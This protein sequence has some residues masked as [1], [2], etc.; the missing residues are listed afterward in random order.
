[1]NNLKAEYARWLAEEAL[2]FYEP[3]TSQ[4]DFHKSQAKIRGIFSGN[5]WGKTYAGCM[6]VAMT[7]DKVHPYRKNRVGAVTARDCCVSFNTIQAVLIPTYKRILPRSKAKLDGKTH[8]GAD[9]IWPG[10]RGGSWRTAWVADD[11]MLHLADGSFIEFKSYEQGREL[12]QGPPRHIIREDE[13]PKEMIHTENLARQFTTG[14]NLIMTMTPLKYSQWCF[15]QIYEASVTDPDIEVFGGSSRDNPYIDL[16]ALETLESM[17]TDEVEKAARLHGEFTFAKGR[18]WPEYGEHNRIPFQK[19]PDDW[20]KSIIIDPHP[21][22]PT[23]V[24][25]VAED[26]AGRLYCYREAN[27]GGTVE[28]I[29]NNIKVETNETISLMLIDPSSRQS[30]AI[31][32]QGSLV[33]EFRKYF[34][35]IIEA[36]NAREAG[37]N[38]VRSMV[39]DGPNGPKLFVMSNCPVTDFQ[40]RN[41]SWKPPTASGED[42]SKPDVVKRNDDHCDNW[43]YRCMVGAVCNTVRF[44]GFK[45]RAYAN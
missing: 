17:C 15:A 42:R 38:K 41:Y 8:E 30:A 3:H 22:K 19:L 40:M 35:R 10:L 14:T 43:R 31:R 26:E 27:Y 34:P 25:W 5:Q 4:L 23:A 44:D 1:M 36:N 29:A 39:V 45:I 18:V 21:E 24:N 32:G 37:W 13:E 20:H 12:F 2:R 33:D 16:D 7:V 11:K 28:E 9:R 6:E